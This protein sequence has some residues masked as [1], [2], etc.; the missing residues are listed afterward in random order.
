MVK[1]K[2]LTF[3]PSFPHP[4]RVRLK[5]PSE[6]AVMVRKVDSL[7]IPRGR[8]LDAVS[9]LTRLL[10]FHAGELSLSSWLV[11]H[12]DDF[13]FSI[14]GRQINRVWVNSTLDRYA[15]VNNIDRQSISTHS[16]RIGAA[17]E[18]HRNGA[19][20]SFIKILGRWHSDIFLTYIRHDFYNTALLRSKYF[21]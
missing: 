17:T 21:V 5:L 3:L 4:R 6:K 15:S 10:K 18:L 7:D 11:I 13:V 9:A 20:D 12:G 16:F 8:L 19:P 14:G 1:W 2:D